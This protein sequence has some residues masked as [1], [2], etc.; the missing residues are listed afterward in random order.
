MGFSWRACR[1]FNT[2]CTYVDSVMKSFIGILGTTTPLVAYDEMEITYLA[3]TN[4]RWLPYLADEGIR[5]VH[6]FAHRVRRQF[7]LD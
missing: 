3:A 2:S 1:D 5:Y 7:A 6:Y 4:S